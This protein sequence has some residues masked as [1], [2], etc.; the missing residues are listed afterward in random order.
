MKLSKSKKMK[1]FIIDNNQYQLLMIGYLP[2]GQHDLNE[3]CELGVHKLED[4]ILLFVF[5]DVPLLALMS[6]FNA[7]KYAIIDVNIEDVSQTNNELYTKIITV[8]RIIDK[9]ELYYMNGDNIFDVITGKY[10]FKNNL[11]HNDDDE[12][13]V[14]K[15]NGDTYYCQYGK[16]HRPDRWIMMSNVDLDGVNKSLCDEFDLWFH[17]K[18]KYVCYDVTD[19]EMIYEKLSKH[20]SVMV[21]YEDYPAIITN[22]ITAYVRDGKYCRRDTDLPAVSTELGEYYYTD[23]NLTKVEYY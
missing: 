16:I 23:G 10:H 6:V 12:P 17:P 3:S 7:S 21:T 5:Y 19:F 1:L 22:T 9:E 13:A 20:E 2:L 8:Q 15:S 14:I 4:G 18:Y 11:L